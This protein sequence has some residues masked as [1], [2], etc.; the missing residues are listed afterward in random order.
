M[1][2]AKG[3]RTAQS[4]RKPPE[5]SGNH[6]VT[7]LPTLTEG[8][9]PPM[10]QRPGFAMP[11]SAD[12]N[13]WLAFCAHN[14]NTP[15][16]DV[17][18]AIPDVMAGEQQVKRLIRLPHV[19]AMRHQEMRDW[20]AVLA[21]LLLWDSW[22][23]DAYWPELKL[24]DYLRREQSGEEAP[25][26]FRQA[27]L[28][29]I[30]RKRASGGLRLFALVRVTDLIEETCPLAVVSSDAVIAPAANMQERVLKRLLPGNVT[31]YD[32]EKNR[33]DDPVRYL[34]DLDRLRLLMQLR[35]LQ[36][37]NMDA[38]L[39]SE[40]SRGENNHLVGLLDQ[41]MQD[42][43]DFR[44]EWRNGVNRGET[45]PLRQ[46]YLRI[47]AVKGLY[48]DGENPCISSIRRELCRLDVA[49]LLQNPLI[50]SLTKT[51]EGADMAGLLEARGVRS[52]E[53]GYYTYRGTP[54]ARE[55]GSYLLE[56]MNDPGEPEALRALE[57]EM[58]MMRDYSSVWNQEFG[59][60]LHAMAEETLLRV[61]AN[62]VIADWL[63]AWSR[64]RMAVPRNANRTITLSYPLQGQP[65]TLQALMREYLEMESLSIIY[66]VFADSLLVIAGPEAEAAPYAQPLA[67]QLR[68]Q[69]D[70]PQGEAHYGVI[71][72]SEDM[73]NWLMT[74]PRASEE[75]PSA[76]AAAAGQRPH[77]ATQAGPGAAPAGRRAAR[78]RAPGL[79]PESLE[80]TRTDGENDDYSIRA[81]YAVRRV[82][83]GDTAIVERV[84][85]FEK[86]FVYRRN[87]QQA[88]L[89][90]DDLIE[91]RRRDELPAV[92]AW[93]N[94]MLPPAQ[95]RL[96]WL[97]ATRDTSLTL[98]AL[99]N[100]SWQNLC[101][102]ERAGAQGGRL[103]LMTDRFPRYLMLKRGGVMCGVLYNPAQPA[104]LRAD[105]A[106]TAGVDFGSTATAVMLQQGRRIFPALLD[107][108]LHG[109]LL[110]NGE[111]IGQRLYDEFIPEAALQAGS[112]DPQ[113]NVYAT[114]LD[115]FT[116]DH[117][118]WQEPLVDGHIYYYPGAAEYRAKD[119]DFLY[120]NLKWGQEEYRQSGVALF[121][122]QS[123]VQTS[124]IARL[125]GAPSIA[126]RFSI[127]T[128]LPD[129]Q[130]RQ[131]LDC[132]ADLAQKVARDTGLPLQEGNAVTYL[133][134][135]G[136]DGAYFLHEDMVDVRSG[137]INMDIGGGS[138]DLS[139]WLGG[140]E[141]P[142][143]E[144][145]LDLGSRS[146]LFDSI[147]R[148]RERFLADFQGLAPGPMLEDLE[149][150]KQS[151]DG[152]L[153]HPRKRD[154]AMFLMDQWL[155]R[156]AQQAVELLR[157][158][159]ADGAPAYTASLV[160]LAFS[161]LY[162]LCGVLLANAYR[163]PQQRAKLGDAMQVC[164]A[165]NGGQLYRFL[166]PQQQE[167]VRR[168]AALCAEPGQPPM[169]LVGVLSPQPKQEIAI[170]LLYST[171][172]S[173]AAN[174]TA[175]GGALPAAPAAATTDGGDG[176]QL[177]HF[178]A[179]FQLF[180]ELFP[181]ESALLLREATLTDA[182]TTRLSA[183]AAYLL[184]TAVNNQFAA[185]DGELPTRYVSCLLD[186][187][188][189]W[190]V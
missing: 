30:S 84:V 166:S 98:W 152:A 28:K 177:E 81:A 95:W 54:F 42:L 110:H 144:H 69:G 140:E 16:T 38:S 160:T 20:R 51:P 158:P 62:R 73:V 82:S 40:L 18:Y 187:K 61:G 122:R 189:A 114:S 8:N 176:S 112:D 43:I 104:A 27:L 60:T 34:R 165:G 33:F 52:T 9:N 190:R 123:M 75:V 3:R 108:P 149:Q 151:L 115:V 22:P 162:F 134:E 32:R 80:L 119:K 179:F 5:R 12:P 126:W 59:H 188:K 90:R 183:D 94:V 101:P 139:L 77:Q 19:E 92:L 49:E 7:C 15:G 136:A 168:F 39:G 78:H 147:A 164:F 153:N 13:G 186:V 121:L 76:D 41:F 116:H 10:E 56:P 93:P 57:L 118:H 120:Y 146:I 167:K 138:C 97:Y 173:S 70:V 2:K 50:A 4:V 36:Q 89:T 88:D 150:F 135:N 48:R 17:G 46:L 44:Y 124:L 143:E 58:T 24:T 85:R 74:T 91:Q 185:E 105:D 35:I 79:V 100:G 65:E 71:P 1:K 137:Y 161:F 109:Y 63:E 181:Q 155:S 25:S 111:A 142:V 87:L 182:G 172:T 23:K 47:A 170:G 113:A 21:I 159:S 125:H 37:F 154:M 133:S 66:N 175:H 127:P 96:Y 53:H 26:A 45:E 99:K 29:A 131:Y 102:S 180:M 178:Q 129:G 86:T 156:Y 64:E 141:A 11:D 83:H 174:L 14:I 130:S 106:V 55:D 68:V 148:N 157:G 169:T 184:R 163:Q 132:V 31:W 67:R 107:R 145:S 117:A 128:A 72:M 103:A 6:Y 171:R